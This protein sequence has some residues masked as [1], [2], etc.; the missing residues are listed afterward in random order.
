L[1]H[2]V[3]APS[4]CPWN[5]NRR[6]G[7]VEAVYVRVDAEG[8]KRV[9]RAAF[10]EAAMA[11]EELAEAMGGEKPAD[12]LK[13][14]RKK[15]RLCVVVCAPDDVIVGY[16]RTTH[17]RLSLLLRPSKHRA[18]DDAVTFEPTCILRMSRVLLGFSKR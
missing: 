9:P 4:S 8:T 7:A 13:K 12:S 15:G 1:Y 10:W 16:H 3:R 2:R 6:R 17:L 18:S 14:K 5:A 11:S